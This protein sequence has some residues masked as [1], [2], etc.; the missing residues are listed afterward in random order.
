MDRPTDRP[1]D[2][3]TLL[4]RC[5]DASKN[6]V[7]SLCLENGRCLGYNAPVSLQDDVYMMFNKIKKLNE[8]DQLSIMQ[9]E[10]KF[11]KLLFFELPSD[12][13]LLK[14]Y[15]VTANIMFTNLLA[16]HVVE[17]N[18]Q[19]TVSVEDIYEI[20]ENL[21]LPTSKPKQ[22]TKESANKVATSFADLDWP[23][24]EE[25]FVITFDEKEWNL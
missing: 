19:V 22:K 13:P 9:R 15:N 11:K 25:K 2:G 24:K 21:T 4:Q 1:T 20:T 8:Q 17:E 5:V 14:Q 3:K 18:N 10:V 16:L 12:Y 6:K 7:L 23:P